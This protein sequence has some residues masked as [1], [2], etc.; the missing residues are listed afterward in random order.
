[1]GCFLAVSFVTVQYEICLAVKF[2]TGQWVMF[3]VV[4]CI[5]EL[6]LELCL[7]GSVVTVQCAL[8]QVV[9]FTMVVSSMGC[10]WWCCLLLSDVGYCWQHLLW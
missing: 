8:F 5:A 10:F 6:Y 4:P 9:S 3:L 1:M 2:V 7:A